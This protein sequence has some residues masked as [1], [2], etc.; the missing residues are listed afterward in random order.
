MQ[1]R[2]DRFPCPRR[3]RC[4]DGVRRPRARRR[5]SRTL[6]RTPLAER[7]P[8]SH[9]GDPYRWRLERHRKIELMA[10]STPD[11]FGR[12]GVVETFKPT[13]SEALPAERIPTFR[14]FGLHE[15]TK[16]RFP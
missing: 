14:T 8:G 13:A 4:A 5:R 15:L 9:R 6:V 10:L 3:H 1:G 16:H 12:I 7:R 11:D 2:G